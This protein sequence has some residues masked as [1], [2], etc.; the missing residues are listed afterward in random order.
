MA[1]PDLLKEFNREADAGFKK[2]YW[3]T[4]AIG[5]KTALSTVGLEQGDGLPE[6]ANFEIMAAYEVEDR[7]AK[8]HQTR[9]LVEVRAERNMLADE[10]TVIDPITG[11]VV[12][13]PSI[14]EW[15]YLDC[16]SNSLTALNVSALTSLHTLLCQSNSLTSL[17]LSSNTALLNLTCSSNRLESLTLS[18]LSLI[19]FLHAGSNLL[20]EADV[21]ALLAL[22]EANAIDNGLVNLAGTGN[23]PPSAAGI[24]SGTALTGRGWNVS[25]NS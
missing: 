4:Y 15:G 23:E 17:D 5:K 19:E 18:G 9:R 7:N 2:V 8:R 25:Y 14:S 11:P 1:H 12:A 13:T 3:R 16:R 10:A 22:L 21:D 6:D 24:T 20:L